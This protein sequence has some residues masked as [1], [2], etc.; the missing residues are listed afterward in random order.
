[1]QRTDKQTNK[2]K[3]IAPSFGGGN[4]NFLRIAPYCSEDTETLTASGQVRVA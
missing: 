3:N 4:N 2:G 1:M